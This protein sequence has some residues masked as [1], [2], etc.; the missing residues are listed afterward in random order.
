MKNRRPKLRT[1]KVI[2][3]SNANA[4]DRDPIKKIPCDELKKL[5]NELYDR[6]C[7]ESGSD[8]DHKLYLSYINEIN[9]RK[10]EKISIRRRATN[11]RECIRTRKQKTQNG[12]YCM[13][14]NIIPDGGD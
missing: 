9:L 1:I 6:W 14:V 8:E 3:E 2:N 7:W 4:S 11:P 13:S 5:A 10:L 12:E